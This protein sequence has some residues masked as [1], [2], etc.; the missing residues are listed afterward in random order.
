MRRLQRECGSAATRPHGRSHNLFARIPRA[1]AMITSGARSLHREVLLH[2]RNSSRNSVVLKLFG[3][4]RR[5]RCDCADR[6]AQMAARER[7]A[8]PGV[9]RRG[10]GIPLRPSLLPVEPE[11]AVYAGGLVSEGQEDCAGVGLVG[12]G[13]C[14]P[15]DGHG[16]E[17]VSIF[18]RP[19]VGWRRPRDDNGVGRRAEAEEPPAG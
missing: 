8:R 3:S 7:R 5:S 9:G 2:A 19:T 12:R 11:E 14:W 16:G 15:G 13:D 4:G 6:E 18:E 10:F 17:R 1:K